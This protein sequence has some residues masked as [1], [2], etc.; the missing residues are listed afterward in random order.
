MKIQ[1]VTNKS[2]LKKFI[3]FPYTFHQTTPNWIAPLKL[4]Q[5]NIFNPQKNSVLLHCD[6]ELFLLYYHG[7]IVGRI[8]VYFNRVANEYWGEN[9][10]FFGHYECYNNMDMAFQLLD[11][12]E[13]WLKF[14][15]MNIMRGPWNFGT[16]DIGFICDGFG[17]QPTVLSSYNPP[18]Y[19]NHVLKFGMEKA[20]D[21][22]VYNCDTSKGYKIPERFLRLTDKITNRYGVKVRPINMK[23]LVE[24][25]RTILRITNE[26]I[27]DNWGFYPVN[28]TEAEQIAADLKMIVHPE[29]VLIAEVNDEPIGYILAL[30]DVNEILKKLN[31]SLL[32]LGIFKL[33]WGIKKINRYRVW[34]MGFLKQY[35]K[36]GISV[37]LFRHLH[38]VL[39]HKEIYVEANWVLED[40]YLMNNALVQLNFDL[41]KKYR[42]YEKVIL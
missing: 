2:L 6:Y 16:Q 40:N 21:L 7:E 26:S 15:G 27:G 36:K 5:K 29:V 14:R 18:Y 13:K 34:A 11:S 3:N 9:I 39:A 37:L 28:E 20:K 31:G 17:L 4:D 8:A 23:N 19:N 41:V 25:A 30:P 38:E 35:Q 12:A 33:L 32:P 10:G 22:L 24:D 42:I 1:P